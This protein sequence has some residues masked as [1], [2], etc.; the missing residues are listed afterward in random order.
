MAMDGRAFLEVAE[1]LVLRST[2]ADWRTAAG[3]AY[4]GVM[5]ECRAALRR[6]GF[7]IP[8]GEQ[9]HRF[10]RLRLLYA[11]DTDLKLVA[12]RLEQL[13]IL[14]NYAD[15]ELENPGYFANDSQ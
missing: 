10:V 5:L 1:R 14:R 9:V 2:E 13:G 7:T 12:K 4:Y 11:S 8:K 3:R 15:Y 6:W